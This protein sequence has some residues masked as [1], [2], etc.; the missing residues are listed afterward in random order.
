MAMKQAGLQWERQ[1][2]AAGLSDTLFAAEWDRLNAG[3]TDLPF[4]DAKAVRSALQ[5][6][7]EGREQLLV[8]RAGGRTAAMF[9][10]VP[11]G[12]FRWQ[13]FQPSQL[14][15][16]A[17][18]A[19]AAQP[20]A[21]LAESLL[22][23]PL[24]SC[25]V[26]SI[27]QIDPRFAPRARDDARR[28]HDDYIDIGW[29]DIEGTFADYWATRGK[30][31]R[32]NMRKQRNKLAADGV[33]TAMRVLRRPD[34]MAPA[35]SR[36]SALESAGWKADEGTAIHIANAQGRFYRNLL[37]Q[38]AA[39]GEALVYEYLFDERT[40]AANLCLI[41]GGVL[42]VLKTAYDESIRSLSPAFLLREEELQSFFSGT[43]VRRVEYYGRLMD[44]HTRLTEQ[45]RTLYH[46]TCYRWGWLRQ[47]AERRRRPSATAP[48]GAATRPLPSAK[49]G[50]E[51]TAETPDPTPMP[52][53]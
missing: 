50:S 53:Q 24:V 23:G 52:R 1:P 34:D 32:Q 33:V 19:D 16:S 2:A 45:R 15:L 44:W 30:N 35:L 17:W 9:V 42:I 4:L 8:G 6:F 18:V 47:L 31:M 22:R 37:E 48:K 49:P 20:I 7:G 43:E 39:C 26:L 40:V 27:T 46:L 28:R 11:D 21:V 14:P 38:A 36:Y 25:L 51:A 29:L 10:L 12:A 5:I 41:R 3:N 13:T